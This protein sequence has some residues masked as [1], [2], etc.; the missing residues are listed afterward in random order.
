MNVGSPLGLNICVYD[1]EIENEIGKPLGDTSGP[2]IGWEDHDK[3]GLSV[4]CLFDYLTGEYRV[5]MQD[6]LGDLVNRLNKAT[7]VVA[8]NHINFDNRLLMAECAKRQDGSP[9]P[10]LR[11]DTT[12]DGPNKVDLNN[13]DMLVEGR[14]GMGWTE[15]ARWPKGCRLD[16]FLEGTFGEGFMKTANGEEAPRMWQ[17]GE[18]GACTDYCLADVKRE[19]TLFEFVWE[20]GFALTP[21]HGIHKFDDPRAR[22]TSAQLGEI[23][24]FNAS[25]KAA[26]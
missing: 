4:G 12:T 23:S 1:L 9:F 17:R 21:L 3:M 8:F 7:M 18:I 20:H 10:T 24:E 13:Y 11:P 26:G 15:G 6:N 22:F 16:N 19:K 2:A 5:F 25:R 14:K